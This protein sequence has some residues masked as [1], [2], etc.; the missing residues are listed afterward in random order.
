MKVPGGS[1]SNLGA[2][3]L[4]IPFTLACLDTISS[5]ETPFGLVPFRFA[6]KLDIEF[7]LEKPFFSSDHLGESSANATLLGLDT[8]KSGLET[9]R[10][11]MG[12]AVRRG[13]A[14]RMGDEGSRKMDPDSRKGDARL[15]LGFEL[16]LLGPGSRARKGDSRVRRDDLRV[17]A[18]S[19]VGWSSF[20]ESISETVMSETETRKLD[21]LP[22]L[23]RR[24]GEGEEG[25]SVCR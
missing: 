23:A 5:P 21:E 3:V 9:S 20:V 1:S 13:E 17:P 10:D 11:R 18:A 2:A 19:F 24:E 12:D 4:I 7:E 25:A 16:G 22:L 14:V 6:F 15:G 8:P